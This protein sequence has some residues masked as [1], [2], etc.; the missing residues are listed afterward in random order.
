MILPLLDKRYN[1]N[2]PVATYA[3]VILNLIIFLSV[4]P[5]RLEYQ[6]TVLK[7]GLSRANLAF[8]PLLTH[9]FLHAQPLHI[10]GN[11]LAL[12][13][14]GR[15]LE[16]LLGALIFVPFY[17]T[18]GFIA[19]L[20]QVGLSSMADLPLIGASGAIYG[21]I[22]GYVV[23]F[24]MRKVKAVY[25][26]SAF[27]APESALLEISA[28]LYV[29]LFILFQDLVL[30]T[31]TGGR[32]M[33]GHWAHFGGF[34]FGAGVTGLLRVAGFRGA[35]EEVAQEE[36][37][38]PPFSVRRLAR[39]RQS[40]TA[41]RRRPPAIRR[42]REIPPPVEEDATE[43]SAIILLD[44][45][46]LSPE[47]LATLQSSF[48]KIAFSP[49]Y[50]LASNL[51]EQDALAI[52]RLLGRAGVRH[53]VLPQEYLVDPP[54]VDIVVSIENFPGDIIVFT[55]RF[56]NSSRRRCADILMFCAA[57]VSEQ[58][59]Q[60]ER[61]ASDSP[62][63]SLNSYVL[64]VYA[65][66]PWVCY[67]LIECSPDAPSQALRSAAHLLTAI[68]PGVLGAEQLR[69]ILTEGEYSG[70]RFKTFGDY[71]RWAAWQLQLAQ[72]HRMKRSKTP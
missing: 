26:L 50:V 41:L 65:S 28:W 45:E 22:A 9:M 19:G 12:W 42:V 46:G 27:S 7:Y 72:I 32:D 64:D 66:N 56:G 2:F 68:L 6:A 23:F 60:A 63:G 5:A 31:F 17:L 40:Q 54:K 33:V 71:D 21:V 53:Y 34:A 70:K 47:S 44:E 13:F 30:F 15:N 38:V 59:S 20:A 67:R 55:D 52:S 10:L 48:L 1:K 43:L 37:P 51:R 39:V 49:Q 25:L 16:R 24:P 3:L 8:V 58:F 14:F 18:G 62:T 36:R 4:R 69:L 29:I 11:M 57:C 61:E 35:P